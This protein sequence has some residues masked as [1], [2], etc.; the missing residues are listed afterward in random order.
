[1]AALIPNSIPSL[2]IDAAFAG[3]L[4][5]GIPNDG[6]VGTSIIKLDTLVL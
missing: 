4:I 3:I 5:P 6:G 2:Y 1:M